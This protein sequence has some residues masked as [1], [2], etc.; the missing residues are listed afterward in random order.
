MRF[1]QIVSG[2]GVRIHRERIELA[3][4]SPFSSRTLTL[5]PDLRGRTWVRV[6]AWDVATDGAFA[7]PVWI[8]K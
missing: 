1:A 8:E 2:D 6:E 7:Q 5:R 3:D 4:T